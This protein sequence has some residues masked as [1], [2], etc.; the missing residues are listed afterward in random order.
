[1]IRLFQFLQQV[2]AFADMAEHEV[3]KVNCAK[4]QKAYSTTSN[5]KRHKCNDVVQPNLEPVRG[6]QRRNVYIQI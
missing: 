5:L 4:C 3:R 2:H 1:M 6:L